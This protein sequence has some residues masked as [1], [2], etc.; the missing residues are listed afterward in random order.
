MRPNRLC[1]TWNRGESWAES[2]EKFFLARPTP[3]F[4]STLQPPWLGQKALINFEPPM[5]RISV[6]TR[7]LAAGGLPQMWHLVFLL[8]CQHWLPSVT[9][10]GAQH[11][12]AHTP[13]HGFTWP[14]LNDK[15]KVNQHPHQEMH[16][17]HAKPQ[18]R[19]WTCTLYSVQ[20]RKVRP[21][22]RPKLEI[23]FNTRSTLDLFSKPMGILGIGY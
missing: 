2:R 4:S 21:D 12:P 7:V 15:D 6:K 5:N 10:Q 19:F 11:H 14:K 13:T 3:T 9:N 1:Q 22:T 16:T 17:P 8:A 23:F 20:T 18:G